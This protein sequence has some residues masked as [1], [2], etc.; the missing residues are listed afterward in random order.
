MAAGKKTGGRKPGTKNKKTIDLAKTRAKF[1]AASTAV[2][3]AASKSRSAKVVKTSRGPR[4]GMS[5]K[6]IL[7]DAMREAHDAYREQCA[8]SSEI[9]EAANEQTVQALALAQLDGETTDAFKSRVNEALEVAAKVREQA[10][11]VRGE[12]M[13]S[14]NLALDTA[15]KVA[16]YDH[17]KLQTSTVQGE[18]TLN[19][20]LA[21]F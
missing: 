2:V 15:H 13:A 1:L 11:A 16:P 9:M 4:D 21:K 19:V 6:D 18:M 10:T 7:V 12:A 3:V 5:A 17:A 8:K 20:T 14:L